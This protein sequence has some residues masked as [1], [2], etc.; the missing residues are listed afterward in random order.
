MMSGSDEQDMDALLENALNEF[1]SE[2]QK[3]DSHLSENAEVQAD[4]QSADQASANLKSDQ[5]DAFM[6]KILEQMHLLS[7]Q[8]GQDR[9]DME[10]LISTQMEEYLNKYSD[11]FGASD[12]QSPADINKLIEQ[13]LSPEEAAAVEK[14]TQELVEEFNQISHSQSQSKR[15]KSK[16]AQKS[17]TKQT[18]KEQSVKASQ[19]AQS[20][21]SSSSF[22]SKVEE[23]ME[24]LKQSSQKVEADVTSN[25]KQSSNGLGGLSEDALMAE[26]MKQFT[27]SQSV[28][29]GDGDD[30]TAGLGDGSLEGLDG[31]FNDIVS[32]MMDT[33]MSKEVLYDPLKELANKYPSYL[34]E[35]KE[36]IPANDYQRYEKQMKCCVN[37]V[38]E[39][40]KT[41]Y[42]QERIAQLMN[43]MQECG[44]PP[45]DLLKELAPDIELDADGMPKLPNDAS[46]A[47]SAEGL[48][49]LQSL[50]GGGSGEEQKCPVM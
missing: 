35:N 8:S 9:L 27:Q 25:L 1:Q 20:Q 39:Y 43:E 45:A 5:A 41:K 28:G 12:G 42:N 30:A 23:T 49:F 46:A 18:V 26:M 44:S 16:N 6:A 32:S 40:E 3:V 29:G 22:S 21:P 13:D 10:T 33:L 24:R 7:G 2:Q 15:R 48:Q 31:A 19:N 47:G 37:I 38:Q 4:V 14:L 34:Q 36:K 11:A 17:S 50:G